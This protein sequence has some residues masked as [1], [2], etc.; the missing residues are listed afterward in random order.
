MKAAIQKK[1]LSDQVTELSLMTLPSMQRECSLYAIFNI[2]SY[3]GSNT[4]SQQAGVVK[5]F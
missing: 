4:L 1:A 5:C 3:L 2:V